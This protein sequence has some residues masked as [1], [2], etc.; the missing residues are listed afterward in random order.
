[1][2]DPNPAPTYV[3]KAELAKILSV[4]PRTID[5]WLANW[6]IPVF[7][8]S[9]KLRLFD[10]EAVRV[11]TEERCGQIPAHRLD[12]GVTETF[13]QL[14]RRFGWW[15]LAGLETVFRLADWYASKHTGSAGNA[16]SPLDARPNRGTGGVA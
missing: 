7:A 3:R 12:S 16:A 8:P 5:T 4:S 1:M 6:S 14:T 11:P 2:T 13:W 9:P 10:V 15:G